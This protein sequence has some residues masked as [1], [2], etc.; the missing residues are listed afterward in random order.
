MQFNEIQKQIIANP[1]NSVVIGA[2]GTGKTMVIVAKVK[3]LLSQGVAPETIAI[4]CFTPKSAFLF[5]SLL[6]K[7]IGNDAKR[8]K[9]ATFKDFAETELK[10]SNSLVGEFAD[11]SQ[12]R[13]LLHQAKTATGFKGSIHEAEHIIRGFKSKAKKPQTTDDNYDIFSKYQDLLHNRN[14]YDRYD[15]LR[16][17]LISLRNDMAQPARFKHM[18]IDNAQDMNQI[19]LLWTLEHAMV[20]IKVTLCVDDDQ[21][22][23]QRSGAMGSKVIDTVLDC[24][25]RFTKY[26]L[27]KSYRLTENLKEQAYK[28]VSLAD[29]RYSKGE[30]YAIERETSVEVKEFNSR[31]QEMD[32]LIS[33]IKHYFKNNPNAKAAVITR[34]D[35]DA[36]FIAKYFLSENF[37][38]TDFSRNIWE[39]PGAI[40]VI[41]VLEVLLGIANDAS[42]KNVLSTLGVH[43]KTIDSMFSKGL[44]GKAWLQNGAKVDKSLI[45]DEK[46]I[47]KII[48]IQSI[49]TSYYRLR[50][51]MSIKDIFKA[52]CFELMRSMSPED[53]KDALYAIEKVLHFKG[54]IKENIGLIR[55]EK[56]INPNAQ[57]VLGP[58][59]EFRNF[60]FDTVFMPF[61]GANVY[62]YDYKVLGKKNSA[63]RRIF[64]AAMTRSKG[65]VYISYSGIPSTYVKALQR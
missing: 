38:F 26:I 9:Y 22:I 15:C 33:N 43:S 24:E 28:V 53:K 30:L 25:A 10:S 35:E 51:K 65:P 32:S 42:L 57:L 16:Q 27:D 31:K 29:Q 23:F 55:K 17:H 20:G 21:C 63:D 41:D 56:Q 14:W 36:R 6:L 12:M 19:Q 2:P 13:R 46:E 48:Q 45:A 49:L 64:F 61:C 1:G 60:E 62:P 11:N 54:D 39:M 58:V 47:K 3:H 5:K 37:P 44:Q 4:S 18:F 34:S 52:L 8:I 59:R 50:T 40:V 7:Y